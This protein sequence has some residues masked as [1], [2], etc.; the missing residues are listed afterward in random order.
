MFARFLIFFWGGE[1]CVGK[2]FGWAMF[3][4]SSIYFSR[5]AGFFLENKQYEKAVEL[6]VASRQCRK[7][8]ELCLQYNIALTEESAEALSLDEDGKVDPALL[9][10]VASVCY[11]QGNYHLA[12]KKWTQ[13]GNR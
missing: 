7:A 6:F 2:T 5:A 13:A 12:T 10:E 9:D 8:L 1:E 4:D 11:R 3:R